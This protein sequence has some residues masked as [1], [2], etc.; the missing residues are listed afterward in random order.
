MSRMKNRR[1]ERKL[2]RRALSE[3]QMQNWILNF[4]STRAAVE[5]KLFQNFEN[6]FICKKKLL[7]Q[8]KITMILINHFMFVVKNFTHY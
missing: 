2:V 6:I 3:R 4:H 1:K 5:L 8:L 7:Y